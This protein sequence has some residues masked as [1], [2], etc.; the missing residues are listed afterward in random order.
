MD[1]GTV[2]PNMKEFRLAMRQFTINE[3]FELHI[4]KSKPQVLLFSNVRQ[5]S[6]LMEEETS[7]QPMHSL[8]GEDTSTPNKRQGETMKKTIA[9]KLMPRKKQVL[10][11]P[12]S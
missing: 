9:K 8:M 11:Q 10:S 5:L 3:E 4:V 2:Y 6:L 1:I 12:K 7:P